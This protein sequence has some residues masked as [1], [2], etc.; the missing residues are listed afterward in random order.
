MKYVKEFL[1]RKMKRQPLGALRLGMFETIPGTDCKGQE[2]IVDG[3]NTGMYV[4]VED[5]YKWL[6]N[7]I[8]EDMFKDKS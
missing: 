8:N 5:Y 3:I 7:V 6:E 4:A 2:I 1:I